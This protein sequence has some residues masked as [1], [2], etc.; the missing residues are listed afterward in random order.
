M[1]KFILILYNLLFVTSQNSTCLKT[2]NKYK[3]F[4]TVNDFS[5]ID[6]IY[7][8]KFML[9]KEHPI[10]ISNRISKCA[11]MNEDSIIDIIDLVSLIIILLEKDKPAEHHIAE[12][13]QQASLKKPHICS[14]NNVDTPSKYQLLFTFMD[15]KRNRSQR[16]N[17][18]HKALAPRRRTLAALN[19]DWIHMINCY[20]S[21]LIRNIYM[22]HRVYYSFV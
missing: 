6:I 22:S 16:R 11:D 7:L 1:R 3:S 8:M 10:T 5:I 18:P 19:S 21:I 20:G 12:F 14:V 17:V 13:L 15:T 2:E 4:D 9:N